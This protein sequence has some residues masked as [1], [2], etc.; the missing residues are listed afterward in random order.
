MM[1]DETGKL[2]FLFQNVKF[3]LRS[4]IVFELDNMTYF[5]YKGDGFATFVVNE[6][7]LL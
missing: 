1:P 3:T 6:L 4:L 7:K 5:G 2:D